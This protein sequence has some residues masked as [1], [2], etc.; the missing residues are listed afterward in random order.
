MEHSRVNIKLHRIPERIAK[1]EGYAAIVSSSETVSFVEFA[2]EAI[3]QN[4]FRMTPRMM[5]I[6]LEASLSNRKDTL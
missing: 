6:Y 5:Q 2:K 1:E 3:E 4:G